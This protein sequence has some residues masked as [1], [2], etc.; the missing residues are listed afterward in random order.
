VNSAAIHQQLQALAGLPGVLGASLHDIDGALT[1]ATAGHEDTARMTEA[2]TDHWRLTLRH[3]GTFGGLARLRVQ[4]L[5][6]ER[7]R[8]TMV[9]CPN[10]LLLVT[11]SAEPDAV[12]WGTWKAC[13]GLLHAVIRA[14]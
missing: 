1:W 8:I 9:A 4:V 2:A 5:I 13:V 6:H 3:G 14:T 10:D 11:V 7:G 12:D